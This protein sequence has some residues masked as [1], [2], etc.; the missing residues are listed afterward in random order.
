MRLD[1]PS[2]RVGMP[3]SLIDHWVVI[4]DKRVGRGNRPNGSGAAV[5]CRRST[6]GRLVVFPGRRVDKQGARATTKTQRM[7]S[8]VTVRARRIME[9]LLTV[10]V[11]G[12]RAV[13]ALL[14]QPQRHHAAA[15]LRED[16]HRPHPHPPCMYAS[17]AIISCSVELHGATMDSAGATRSIDVPHHK[18]GR[19]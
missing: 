7:N 16:G 12:E 2:G 9:L 17:K 13:E 4:R 8:V 11:G 14:P 15:A 1:R 18:A 6:A 10:L 3:L 19:L 5:Q